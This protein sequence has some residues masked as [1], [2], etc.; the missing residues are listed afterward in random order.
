MAIRVEHQ[1]SGGAVGMAAY[2]SGRGKARER[3]QKYAMDQWQNQQQLQARQQQEMRGY[4]FKYWQNEQAQ[5]RW[6]LGQQAAQERF[7]LTQ[8]GLKERAAATQQGLEKRAQAGIAA[9][10]EQAQQAQQH[11]RYLAAQKGLQSGDLMLTPWADTKIK[12]INQEYATKEAS[13]EL[14]PEQLAEARQK[15]DEKIRKITASGTQPSDATTQ[16]KAVGKTAGYWK[17]GVFTIGAPPGG[18]P[19]HIIKDGEYVPIQPGAEEAA[20]AKAK[21][22]PTHGENLAAT[23]SMR[24]KIYA[25]EA[26]RLG[27]PTDPTQVDETKKGDKKKYDEAMATVEAEAPWPVKG[28]EAAGGGAAEPPRKSFDD[29]SGALKPEKPGAAAATPEQQTGAAPDDIV[30]GSPWGRVPGNQTGA[31]ADLQLPQDL[32]PEQKAKADT[33]VDMMPDPLADVTGQQFGPIVPEPAPQAG[34]GAPAEFQYADQA[35]AQQVAADNLR[36]Q[37]NVKAQRA[38]KKASIRQNIT[39]RAQARSGNLPRINNDAEWEQLPRGQAFI[40]PD[41]KQYRKH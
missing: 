12:G 3:K 28:A 31:M 1:P 4:Q 15:A 32:T 17:D 2:A 11:A 18:K 13:G 7:G 33:F 24:D 20:A 14:D 34:I 22:A 16:V 40:G 10:G 35:K 27:I 36:K 39:N 9:R 5:Q 37:K 25:A 26:T 23:K 38:A 8:Q 6:D 29:A 41:G 30:F 21:P 19:T